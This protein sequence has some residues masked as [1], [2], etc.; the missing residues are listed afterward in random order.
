MFSEPVKLAVKRKSHFACCLC[1]AVGVEVHHIDPQAQ[2]G[3]DSADNAAA[4]CPSCHE[5][6]GAN[7][8]KRKFI[9][10][11]RDL[12]YE[13][14]EERFRGDADQLAA[15]RAAMSDVATKAD[16][17]A[18]VERLA[19]P[20]GGGCL[21][22]HSQLA[23]PP[24]LASRLISAT[25]IREYLCWMYPTLTHCGEKRCR[26]WEDELSKVNY[27]KIAE[28]HDVIGETKEPVA[29]Y[30]QE[31]ESL[32]GIWI[33]GPTTC[34]SNFLAVLDEQYCQ[35]YYPKAYTNRP[36]DGPWRRRAP[37]G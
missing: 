18:A 6:Y 37:A 11:A 17:E 19:N 29:D 23:L 10:E 16:L 4:L 8:T 28:L 3:R 36:K 24:E 20:I 34:Q 30:V 22:S 26:A 5:T 9:R 2:G 7:P 33:V 14:C 32:G 27:S 15:L 25:S 12:W 35:L 1:H 31:R 21:D 13:I